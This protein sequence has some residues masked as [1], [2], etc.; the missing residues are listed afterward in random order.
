M[1]VYVQ[2]KKWNEILRK[3]TEI[4][5]RRNLLMGYRASDFGIESRWI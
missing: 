4:P 2:I 1:S 3:R 5:N